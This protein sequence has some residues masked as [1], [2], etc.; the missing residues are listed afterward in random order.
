MGNLQFLKRMWGKIVR[1]ISNGFIKR[2]KR[3]HRFTKKKKRLLFKCLYFCLFVNLF[4]INLSFNNLR[5]VD[6]IY[7]HKENRRK[8]KIYLWSNIE[9]C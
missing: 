5:A 1:I 9:N 7:R 4:L 3:K 6:N 2:D 8:N